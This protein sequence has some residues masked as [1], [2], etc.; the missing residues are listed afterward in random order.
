V[1]NDQKYQL[2]GDLLKSP[3]DFGYNTA[4][5]TGALV[6]HHLEKSYPATV[7]LSSA[8]KLMHEV[9]F[10]Y[11]FAKAIYHERDEAKRTLAKAEIKKTSPIR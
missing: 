8:Y 11:Q 6:R 9:G 3:E 4:N 5:W 10:S 7:Q 1:T 2:Q